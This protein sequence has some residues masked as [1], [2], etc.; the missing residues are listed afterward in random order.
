MRARNNKKILAL[1]RK[2]AELYKGQLE[3]Q[4]INLRLQARNAELESRAIAPLDFEAGKRELVQKILSNYRLICEL[5][6]KITISSAILQSET[7]ALI[8]KKLQTKSII[9]AASPIWDDIKA[10][11]EKEA[12]GFLDTIDRI[13]G[14]PNVEMLRII[15]LIRVGFRSVDIAELLSKASN[16]IS[17]HKGM[18]CKEIFNGEVS[19]KDL[20]YV[21]RSISV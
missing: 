18:L 17:S 13:Y 2:E 20:E 19:T 1:Q 9:P 5:Q 3:I 16:T 4:K 6:G 8:K 12:P 15:M 11:L 14:K 21:I 7:Y 10:L